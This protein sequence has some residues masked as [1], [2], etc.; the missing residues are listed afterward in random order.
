M[1][2]FLR[3]IMDIWRKFEVKLIVSVDKVIDDE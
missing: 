3:G 2:G 1:Y